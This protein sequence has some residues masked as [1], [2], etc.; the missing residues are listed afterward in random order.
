MRALRTWM[1]VMGVLLAGLMF[2]C[3]PQEEVEPVVQAPLQEDP[4]PVFPEEQVPRPEP[5]PTVQSPPVDTAA[6]Q[7]P[8]AQPKP[9]PKESYA[10]AVKKASRTYLVRKGDTLQKISKKFYGTTKKWRKIYQVNRKALAK[11]P[12][13]LQVG[14]KLIIP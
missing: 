14:M 3:P 13:K 1:L 9:Q 11:G 8:A 5:Q 6:Q 12:D 4:L 2:G 7:E 10:P